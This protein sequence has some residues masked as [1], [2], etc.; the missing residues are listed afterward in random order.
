MKRIMFK[1]VN[2]YMYFTCR[3]SSHILFPFCLNI[4]L[5]CACLFFFITIIRT[6]ADRNHI[7][8]RDE[9]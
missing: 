5:S 1:T 4:V 9:R 7:W 2:W 3:S 8:I 6:A